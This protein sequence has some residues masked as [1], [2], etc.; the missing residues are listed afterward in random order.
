MPNTFSRGSWLNRDVIINL[1]P[2]EVRY[3]RSS[4]VLD[5]VTRRPVAVESLRNPSPPACCSQAVRYSRKS[6]RAVLPA[7]FG[8]KASAGNL[9]VI[10]LMMSLI[11][12]QYKILCTV[13]VFNG[14]RTITVFLAINR[15][16]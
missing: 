4:S 5:R 15:Y 13:S 10:T 11:L 8:R 7:E 2:S 6:E 1:Y 16:L 12:L 14:K 3:D 9:D